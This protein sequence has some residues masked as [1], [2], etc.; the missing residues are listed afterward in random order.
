MKKNR[1]TREGS[2]PV[3]F[4]LFLSYLMLNI[5]SKID[6]CCQCYRA[7]LFPKSAAPFFNQ[8][9][10]ELLFICGLVLLYPLIS[11]QRYVGSVVNWTDL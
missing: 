11:Y 8:V 7:A 6:T 5:S 10:Y 2:I 9:T 3:I 1:P 4:K